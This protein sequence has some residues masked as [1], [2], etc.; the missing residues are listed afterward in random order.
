[1]R[2]TLF[3]SA[4]VLALTAGGAIAESLTDQVIAYLTDRG[5]D[6]IEVKEGPTQLKVEATN[7]V[8]VIELIYDLATGELLKEEH[9]PLDGDDDF[10][11]GV[12][13]DTDD[14]DFLDDD[15]EDDEDDESDEDDEDDESDESDESDDSE[16]DESDD[17][18]EDGESDDE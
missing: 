5:Y 8:D 16:S 14:E 4:A 1:M 7:G 13:Y 2:K 10:E 17:D 12:E 3:T 11:D 18:E 9:E 15:E 6:R